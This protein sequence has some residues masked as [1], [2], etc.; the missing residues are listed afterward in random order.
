MKRRHIKQR[1]YSPRFGWNWGA[2]MSGRGNGR[3]GGNRTVVRK[4]RRERA[5]SGCRF[6]VP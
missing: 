1:A 5:R 3:R 2:D 4:R 6:E